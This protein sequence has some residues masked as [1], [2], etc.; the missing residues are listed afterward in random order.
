M[1]RFNV[2]IRG[3]GS[4]VK[5][6]VLNIQSLFPGTVLYSEELTVGRRRRRLRHLGVRGLI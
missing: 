4:P 1:P 3:K 6:I 5:P 2:L